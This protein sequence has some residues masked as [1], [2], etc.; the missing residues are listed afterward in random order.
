MAIID[1]ARRQLG[2]SNQGG[3]SV[4]HAVVLLKARL[5]ATQNLHC[6]VHRRLNHINLLETT[7]QCCILFKNATVF[8]KGGGANALELAV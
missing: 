8:R 4:F 2:S 3:R 7:R 1:V 6:L 5:E